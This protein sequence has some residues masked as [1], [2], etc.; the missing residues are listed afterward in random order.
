MIGVIV[1]DVEH[2]FFATV[3]AGIQQVANNIG[4]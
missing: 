4:Y 1:P 2:P 3:L